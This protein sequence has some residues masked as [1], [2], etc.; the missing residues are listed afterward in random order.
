MKKKKFTQK[1]I[2]Y[3]VLKDYREWLSF[4]RKFPPYKA[5]LEETLDDI[6]LDNNIDIPVEWRWKFR[7]RIDRLMRIKIRIPGFGGTNAMDKEILK[8]KIYGHN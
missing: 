5:W 3:L 2:W 7:K 6:E 1:E 4:N 8:A